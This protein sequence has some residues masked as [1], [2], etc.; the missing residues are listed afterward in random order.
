MILMKKKCKYSKKYET[1]NFKIK[2]VN[3]D[4]LLYYNKTFHF[5]NNYLSLFI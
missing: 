5:L 4:R 1:K 3:E 2:L